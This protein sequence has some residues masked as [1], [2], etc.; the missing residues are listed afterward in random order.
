MIE[1]LKFKIS[2]TE[3]RDH[4]LKKAEHHKSRAETKQKE[5]PALVAAMDSIREGVAQNVSA[6]NSSMYAMDPDEPIKQME[7][8]I[9]DHIKKS[10]L[11]GFY[12]NHLFEDDYT[13]GHHDLTA[14]ELISYAP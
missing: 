10:L 3:L 6:K 7:K 12:A 5:L 14:L 2:H 4:C 11:F 13:L 9:K 8:D 1:G